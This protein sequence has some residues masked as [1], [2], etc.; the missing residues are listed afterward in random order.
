MVGK[1]TIKESGSTGEMEEP[2]GGLVE[3]IEATAGRPDPKAAIMVFQERGDAVVAEAIAIL[4]AVFVAN[5]MI[6]SG[7]EAVEAVGRAYPELVVAVFA[8]AADIAVTETVAVRW[9]IAVDDH[10]MSVV[11]VE[12]VTGPDPDEAAAVL[13]NG[14]DGAVGEALLAGEV[15]KIQFWRLGPGGGGR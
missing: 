5:K 7:I 9:I 10:V 15:G 14:L 12:S 6:G 8:D 11:A 4:V 13:K 3:A 2:A 1:H